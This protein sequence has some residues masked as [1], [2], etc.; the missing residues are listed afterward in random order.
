MLKNGMRPSG[1]TRGKF[2]KSRGM[3]FSF[4][5]FFLKNCYS[6]NSVNPSVAKQRH[7]EKSQFRQSVNGKTE[8]LGKISILSIPSISQGANIPNWKNIRSPFM[9]RYGERRSPRAALRAAL[10][11]MW[12]RARAALLKVI[13]ER[14]RERRSQKWWALKVSAAHILIKKSHNF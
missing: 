6:V 4:F 9:Q 13:C 12:A 8:V 10:S 5:F 1:R 14:E 3:R 2:W 11:K 7:L